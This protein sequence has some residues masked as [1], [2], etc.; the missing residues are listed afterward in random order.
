M[1]SSTAMSTDRT[2]LFVRLPKAQAAA[3]DRLS[4]AT[5]RPKQHLVSELLAD[6]LRAPSRRLPVG[7]ADVATYPDPRADEVLTLDETA[8]FLKLGADAVRSLAESGEL[9]GRR[10]GKEWRFARVAILA[11]LADGEAPKSRSAPVSNGDG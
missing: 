1:I 8:V 7:R 10:F 3:L 5:G 9:A 4:G 2:P 6:R 11:W